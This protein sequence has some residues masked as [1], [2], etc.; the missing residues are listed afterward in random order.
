MT[1]R[2]INIANNSSFKIVKI[3]LDAESKKRLYNMG[4]FRDDVYIRTAGR[5]NSP[6]II[7]NLSSNAT[8]IAIGNKLA[9]EIEIVLIPA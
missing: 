8:P 6:I 1:H 7:K 3:N 9:E 2:L 4:I 5:G